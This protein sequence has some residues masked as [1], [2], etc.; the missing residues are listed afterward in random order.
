MSERSMRLMAADRPRAANY[1]TSRPAED[2]AELH[3]YICVNYRF[4][5]ASCNDLDEAMI[6]Q[7]W[8][9]TI[10]SDQRQNREKIKTSLRRASPQNFWHA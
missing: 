2:K 3:T 8:Q 1:F 5:T 7:T 6:Q 10:S 9:T 4:D